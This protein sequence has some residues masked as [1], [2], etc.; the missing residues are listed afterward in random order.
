MEF[1]LG[2]ASGT[3]AG[4]FGV[5]DPCLHIPTTVAE[6]GGRLSM[7][8]PAAAASCPGARCAVSASAHLLQNAQVIPVRTNHL[9]D[10]PITNT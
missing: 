10:L 5:G 9:G 6:F 1:N 3:V 2:F 7:I 8:E 4:Q